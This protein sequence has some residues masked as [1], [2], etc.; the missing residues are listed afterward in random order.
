MN[1]RYMAVGQKCPAAISIFGYESY[2]FSIFLKCLPHQKAIIRAFR[3]SHCFHGK[4]IFKKR[5]RFVPHPINGVFM[6]ISVRE[7]M[8]GS[9]KAP[10]K[11][12]VFSQKQVRFVSSFPGKPMLQFSYSKGNFYQI[13]HRVINGGSTVCGSKTE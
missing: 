10:R 7:E 2:P 3:K 5:V 8:N 12:K 11:Y 1:I 9:V 6:R 13:Q 4:E